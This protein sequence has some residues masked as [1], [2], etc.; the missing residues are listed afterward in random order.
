MRIVAG[1]YRGRSLVAPKGAATR[2]TT[3]RVREAVFSALTALE[4]SD[5]GGGEA[6]D[7]FAG[8]GALGLEA[9]SR[10][11]TRVTLVESSRGA[12]AAVK[13]NVAAL[14]AGACARIVVGDVF[15]SAERGLLPGG[16]F[17]L[18]LLDPPYTLSGSEIAR[19]VA[20]LAGHELLED[21]ALIVYEHAS[22]TAVTWPEG[23]SPVARKRYGSTEVDIAR[24]EREDSRS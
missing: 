14:D 9:L 6:L 21:R 8:S 12:V 1:T 3:D 17:S 15:A 23:V 22:G 19:L 2:P 7:A 5:L 4:G 13:R 11:I 24:Y 16:P 20:I 10:G 18:L